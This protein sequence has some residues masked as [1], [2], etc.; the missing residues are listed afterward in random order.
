MVEEE[1]MVELEGI[2]EDV[3]YA[4]RNLAMVKVLTIRSYNFE[5]LNEH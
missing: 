4:S 3:F 1:T 2:E 5:A